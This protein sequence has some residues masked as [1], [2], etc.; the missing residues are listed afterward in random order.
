MEDEA[1]A[2]RKLADGL[3]DVSI[4]VSGI[5]PKNAEKSIRGCLETNTPQYVFTC[6]FAG[7]LDP[8]LKTGDVVFFSIDGMLTKALKEAGGKQAMGVYSSP[9]IVSTAR[10][11]AELWKQN[12]SAVVEMESGEILRV[13]GEHGVPCAMVRTI[14]DTA[15]ED[16]PLDFNQL[17]N[18]DLSLNYSKLAWAIARSPGKIPALLRLQRKC[19]FAA[20]RLAYILKH[21]IE[22]DLPPLER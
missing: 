21:I 20:E 7:A 4:L 16:L 19:K 18:P 8:D 5:G 14:S 3:K 13:C 10:E 12:E 22:L 15:N 1:R 2:F 9:R 17:A 11:K 6:G